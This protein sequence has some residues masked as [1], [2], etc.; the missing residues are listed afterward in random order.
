VYIQ[1]G[2]VRL[3]HVTATGGDTGV[4]SDNA[5]IP[6]DRSSVQGGT[7]LYLGGGHLIV[8]ASRIGGAL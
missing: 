2:S 6:I 8:A 4:G 3:T 5:P 7:A 1:G